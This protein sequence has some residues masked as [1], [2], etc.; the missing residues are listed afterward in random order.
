MFVEIVFLFFINRVLKHFFYETALQRAA[1]NN[2]HEIVF[3]FL[4]NK[5]KE[6][7]VWSNLHKTRSLCI[8]RYIR[9]IQNKSIYLSSLVSIVIPSSVYR[10]TDCAFNQSHNSLFSDHHWQK[11]F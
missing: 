6:T 1:S 3:Y 8:P 4:S 10:I 7:Y 5:N 9:T 2:D 11:C